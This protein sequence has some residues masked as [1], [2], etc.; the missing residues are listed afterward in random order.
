M[1]F[2][3]LKWI[4]RFESLDVMDQVE[5]VESKYYSNSNWSEKMY[6]AHWDPH[7]APF[8]VNPY[9]PWGHLGSTSA[10]STI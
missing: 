9:Q 5:E 1:S 6:V 2:G 3:N 10:A 8:A 7:V 4:G